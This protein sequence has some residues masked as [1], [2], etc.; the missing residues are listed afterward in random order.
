MTNLAFGMKGSNY[1][2]FTGGP[3]PPG[4]GTTTDIYDFDASISAAGEI[5]PLYAAQQEFGQW[6]QAHPDWLTAARLVD[7]RVGL[8]WE[9]LRARQYWTERGPYNVTHNEAAAFLRQGVIS[10]A[11][12]AGL[13]PKLVDLDAED[14]AADLTTPLVIVSSDSMSAAKQQRIVDFLSRGGQA[15]ITPVLPQYD[16]AMAPCSL[17]A[18]FLGGIRQEKN[19]R[20]I[21]RARVGSVLNVNGSTFIFTQAPQAAQV[22]AIDEF[23]GSPLGLSISI[24]GG[25]RAVV[26]GIQW[27][28][29]MREHEA[30]LKEL[31]VGL[32]LRP[33]L[34]NSNPN[35]WASAYTA[36]GRT[37]LF[38]LNLFTQPLEC[39]A[40]VQI[41]GTQ[42]TTGPLTIPPVTVLSLD[43]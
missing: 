37:Y 1:Y 23:S 15:L 16:E 41:N 21:A 33:A 2:I 8:D 31:L 28:Q 9:H 6:I 34:A 30:M 42:H 39:S 12:C 13:S 18:D 27:L 19:P 40:T 20:G 36:Q 38:L 43:L 5:R 26:L 3:N 7:F 24:P 25:G 22:V 35:I 17:L 11:L 10:S 4:C 29:A 14:W 32:G